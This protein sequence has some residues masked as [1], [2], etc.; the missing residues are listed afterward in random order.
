VDVIV[1]RRVD[2][3]AARDGEGRPLGRV[4]GHGAWAMRS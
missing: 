4:L 3:L 2:R 1:A